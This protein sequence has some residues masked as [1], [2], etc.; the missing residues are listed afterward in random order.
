M[1]S[2]SLT[3]QRLT[4]ESALPTAKYLASKHS[5]SAIIKTIILSLDAD[6]KK[7]SPTIARDGCVIVSTTLA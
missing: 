4:S 1:H 2:N 7:E 6:R 3:S 5:V